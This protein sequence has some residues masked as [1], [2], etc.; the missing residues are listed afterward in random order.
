MLPFHVMQGL[1]IIGV[2]TGVGKT[3]VCAGIMQMLHG[4]RKLC[5]WKPV[6]SGTIVGDDTAEIKALTALPADEF[7]EPAYKFPD[8]LSP[9]MAAKKWGKSIEVK[10]MAQQVAAKQK[11]NVFMLIE[12]AGGILVPFNDIE[13]Q[14]DLVR[15]TKLPILIV[16]QDRVGAINQTLLTLNAARQANIPVEGVILTRSRGQLGNAESI[17]S[18]GKIDVLAELPPTD[19]KKSLVAQVG[20]HEKLRKHFKVQRLP[21]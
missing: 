3:V 4:S 19:D 5:Y 12:G 6:Q 8:P 10:L 13:L 11:E 20:A 15:A 9:M 17:S 21:T 16:A 2:D 7:M 14:I 1:Y 18:F